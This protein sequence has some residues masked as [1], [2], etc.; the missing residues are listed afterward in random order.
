MVFPLP[1]AFPFV[2]SAAQIPSAISL[3]MAP[4]EFESKAGALYAN[5]QRFHLKGATW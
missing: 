1:A 3:Q 5:G 2:V 4:M